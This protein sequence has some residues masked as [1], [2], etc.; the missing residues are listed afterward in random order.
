MICECGHGEGVH[1]ILVGPFGH[2]R[3]ATCVNCDCKA[4][5]TKEDRELDPIPM[6]KL[7]ALIADAPYAFYVK[8][9]EHDAVR[10][11]RELRLLKAEVEYL[12]R[13]RELMPLALDHVP[14]GA[15]GDRIAELLAEDSG[16]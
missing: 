6:R 11:F 8:Q 14:P 1:Y 12:K 3:V 13:Y 2:K 10:A 5:V 7:Q 15:L 9:Y 4:L 16:H